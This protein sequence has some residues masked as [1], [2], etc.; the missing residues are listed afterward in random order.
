MTRIPGSG[1]GWQA[2]RYTFR[3]AREVGGLESRL[4]G[5]TRNYDRF[6]ARYTALGVLGRGPSEYLASFAI[7]QFCTKMP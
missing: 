7:L 4:G 5:A 3:K 6:L 2:I 1:G